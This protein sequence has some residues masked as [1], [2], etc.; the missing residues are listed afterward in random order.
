MG[1]KWIA[2]LLVVFLLAGILAGCGGGTTSGK[3]SKEPTKLSFWLFNEVHKQFYE[4]GIEDWNKQYPDKP[5]DVTFEIYPN[6]E[7][8]SKLLIALQSGT[9]APDISDIN[10]NYFSNFLQGD[11]Q[12]APSTQ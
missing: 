5:I 4:P 6:Q 3:G 8:G 12:L 10:I 11:I 7:M 9:G 1:K 2:M